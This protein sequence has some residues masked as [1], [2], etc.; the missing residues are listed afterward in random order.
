MNVFDVAR[1]ILSSIGGEISAMKLQKLCYYS[2]AWT[3]AWDGKELFPEDFLRWDN[4][5]VC[6]ELFDV[7]QGMFMVNRD[8]IDKK[9]LSNN[10]PM[11]LQENIDKVLEDYGQYSGSELSEMTHREKPWA[12]TPRNKVITKECMRKYYSNQIKNNVEE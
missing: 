3:L 12:E 10:L 7:H 9:L 6:R 11:D 2:Q 4:G 5:P 8:V 1:Y